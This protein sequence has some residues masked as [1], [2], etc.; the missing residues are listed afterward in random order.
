MV[1]QRSG[2]GK[3]LVYAPQNSP[4]SYVNADDDACALQQLGQ[5]C[6]SLLLGDVAAATFPGKPG[7]QPKQKQKH[8]TFL[9]TTCDVQKNVKKLRLLGCASVQP[10]PRTL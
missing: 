8:N 7:A 10:A 2:L 3:H 4:A 1:T 9:H 6:L 5:T